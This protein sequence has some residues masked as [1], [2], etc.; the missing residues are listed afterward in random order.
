VGVNQDIG[1]NATWK[2]VST[3]K[4]RQFS[5]YRTA[6]FIKFNLLL[7]RTAKLNNMFK[8]RLFP[9]IMMIQ[10]SL[11]PFS[12]AQQ[13]WQLISVPTAEEVR[14]GF[15]SP[16]PE[17]GPNLVWGCNGT[18]DETVIKRDLD[19][20]RSL[21]FPAV[22]IE[23]GYRMK[24]PY[25]SEGWFNTVSLAVREAKQRGMRVWLIDEGK[26]PSGFAGGK[27]STERPDLR[28]QG[29]EVARRIRP[30]SGEVLDIE[31]PGDILSAAAFQRGT[32]SCNIL[33]VSE[34][35]LE[36]TA[37]DSGW[38]I[39]IVRHRFRTSVTRAANN[40]TG[41]KD[42][43][44]SLCD[45]L[46][47]EATRQFIAFTHEGY[48]RH[49][50]NEFG[51][52]LMGFRGDEP[53]YGFIPWT[54]SIT[55]EFLA[56]K[57]YDIRPYIATF[58]L[59]EPDRDM[60]MARADYWDVWSALFGENF[61]RVQADWCEENNVEYMVHMNHEDKMM[62]LV[63]S[64]GDYF[65]NM[66]HVQ[67]PGVDAI[68]NQIW[69]DR[70][71]DFPKL[72]SSAAHLNGR[73]RA[74]SESFAAYR[75]H[76]NVQQGKWVLDHQFARGINLF[77][78]MFFGS[79]A[80]GRGRPMGWMASDSFPSLMQYTSRVSWLLSQGRPTARIALYMPTPSMWL[81]DDKAN[82]IT[83]EIARQLLEHQ[84]DFD[85]IDEYSLSGGLIRSEGKLV[86]RS[87]QSYEAVIV[88][89]ASVMSRAA[90]ECLES[91]S[92]SG[93]RVLFIGR[94]PGQLYDSVFTKAGPFAFH[95]KATLEHSIELTPR[96]L[97]ILPD[98]DVILEPASGSIKYVHRRLD[99][100]ELYF[101]FNESEADLNCRATLEGTG[102]IEI[103]DPFSGEVQRLV[104]F[105][106]GKKGLTF[107]LGLG[108]WES[109]IFLLGH[110][111]TGLVSGT[112]PDTADECRNM[113]AFK[114]LTRLDWQPGFKDPGTGDWKK[115]WF[116]DGEK[117]KVLNTSKGMEFFAGPVPAEDASH[118]VLW[119]K[120]AFHGDIRIE[121]EYTRLDSATRYVN[122]LYL[123]A[124]GSGAE[125]YPEDLM[126]WSDKRE[127]PA[128]RIYF[129]HMNL[130]HI[131]Y[132]AF[133]NTNAEK[134]ND[135]IRAR[136]YLPETGAGLRGTDLVPD[137]F[138]TG[139]FLPGEKYRITVIK[140]GNDLFMN[141]QSREKEMLCHWDL[142]GFPAIQEG[143]IGLRHMGS[144]DARYRNFIVFQLEHN[145]Q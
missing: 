3:M 5:F 49:L 32:S 113:E 86:N 84:R 79:S 74:M 115:G 78:I 25:L 121:Y 97:E 70:V 136:R 33:D 88:P 44:N 116:L 117:A 102:D 85:F 109:R 21:G 61:F 114:E 63:R 107:N 144:R 65:R 45:Y 37:P 6:F 129:N 18:M 101:L 57:G 126:K 128:M 27:F 80:E 138:R 130:L 62:E 60:R 20:I 75:I 125:G 2:N 66:R 38:V 68:W 133:E 12:S 69:M 52:T 43:V 89:G 28:M 145:N 104:D 98:R 127:I 35:R 31:L 135:Y 100:A 67:I 132:A 123:L 39:L 11:V 15:R 134:G 19:M 41:G 40:P 13:S 140:H 72:A 14:A 56:R 55:E 23:A 46:N 99:D 131:S 91:F 110:S 73:P 54:P 111:S 9:A 83:W 29:L 95:G 94:E 53:D 103:L 24:D 105:D 96:I 47:P 118:T 92:G 1:L 87:G 58:Y 112:P 82:E 34:G 59:P 30:A 36:W 16:P 137:Y 64:G 7:N 119:T 124:T 48:K 50:E 8:H 120:Q 122:I 90:V 139:L 22:I 26:Y 108:P 141:I 143:R 93:G 51:K 71:A 4:R 106:Q 10:L 76:P 42:T 77:E 142:S 81:G 17:Y